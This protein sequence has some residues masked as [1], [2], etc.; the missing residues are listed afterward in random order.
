MFGYREIV[1]PRQVGGVYFS[2]YW[3][4]PYVC[5]G[6][7]HDPENQQFWL[8]EMDASDF[9]P[10]FHSTAWDGTRD[11]V[12]HQPTAKELM[13]FGRAQ[14]SKHGHLASEGRAK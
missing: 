8:S 5:L 10:R 1:G 4:R 9:H 11:A 7:V 14:L 2:G 12:L 13:E 6:I 3:R